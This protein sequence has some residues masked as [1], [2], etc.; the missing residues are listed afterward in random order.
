MYF[1]L[2]N[3]EDRKMTDTTVKEM[4]KIVEYFKAYPPLRLLAIEIINRYGARNKDYRAEALAI[5]KFI[6]EHI[7]YVKD[8][9]GIETLQTPPL[10]LKAKRGDCDDHAILVASLLASIGHKTAFALYKSPGA[11]DYSHVYV[12]DY[13]AMMDIDTTGE[14]RIS[15]IP[16]DR[17]YVELG[18]LPALISAGGA[19]LKTIAPGLVA[20]VGNV[21]SNLIS[22]IGSRNPTGVMARIAQ[23]AG[24]LIRGATGAA[25]GTTP[26]AGGG[27]LQRVI[28]GARNLLN[29]TGNTSPQAQAVTARAAQ[30]LT[31][32]SPRVAGRIVTNAQQMTSPQTMNVNVKVSGAL[33]LNQSRPAGGQVRTGTPVR[34]GVRTGGYANRTTTRVTTAQTGTQSAREKQIRAAFSQARGGSDGLNYDEIVR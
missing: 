9:Q 8:I 19:L 21:A 7:R 4:K 26:A 24:N 29:P 5:E 30:M 27:L 23:G 34:Q 13:E 14:Y 3:V 17:K 1:T 10:T 11:S 18:F 2:Q 15:A 25:G 20:K 22:R 31:T 32:A 16:G 28:G 12:R 33:T 6:K